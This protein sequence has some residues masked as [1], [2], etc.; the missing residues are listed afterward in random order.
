MGSQAC[1]CPNNKQENV[2]QPAIAK[3]RNSRINLPRPEEMASREPRDGVSAENIY[4][5]PPLGQRSFPR[6]KRLNLRHML[7]LDSPPSQ[8]GRL[9]MVSPP[10][11]HLL[12]AVRPGRRR[13]PAPR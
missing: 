1:F 13:R 9:S 10:W 12:R 5:K 11:R 2:K 3:Y 4:Q 6:A 7:A 8:T